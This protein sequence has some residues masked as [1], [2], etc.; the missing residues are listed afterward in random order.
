MRLKP[1][2]EIVWYIFIKKESLKKRWSNDMPKLNLDI[3][4]IEIK[5]MP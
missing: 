2:F 4:I 1:A 3:E 5:D